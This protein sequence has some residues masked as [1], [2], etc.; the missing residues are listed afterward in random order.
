M[1][2]TADPRMTAHVA[3]IVAYFDANI[4]VVVAAFVTVAVFLWLVKIAFR[5]LGM[6]RSG[7]RSLTGEEYDAQLDANLE[8]RTMTRGQ[9]AAVRT[10][11]WGDYHGFRTASEESRDAWDA[12]GVRNGRSRS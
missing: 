11:A 1:I 6:N 9:Y 2:F 8:S 12:S 5:S 7:Y 4:P 3:S 10:S